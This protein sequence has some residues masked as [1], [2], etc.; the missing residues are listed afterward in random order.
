MTGKIADKTR[1]KVIVALRSA[2]PKAMSR[3]GIRMFASV[4]QDTLE[5]LLA[6]FKKNKSIEEIDISGDGTVFR[7][8]ED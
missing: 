5:K 7:W 1:E 4:H 2:Y 6:E 3:N 8:I